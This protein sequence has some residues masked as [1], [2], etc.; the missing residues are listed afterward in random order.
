MGF[1]VFL[2]VS[3]FMAANTVEKVGT[4][5]ASVAGGVLPTGRAGVSRTI[6]A[7]MT[8]LFTLETLFQC[9]TLQR[10]RR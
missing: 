2:L 7:E 5:G 4:F 9:E 10:R 8:C 1:T 6:Y 3:S